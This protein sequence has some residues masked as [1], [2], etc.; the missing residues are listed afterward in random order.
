MEQHFETHLPE[1]YQAFEK[2]RSLHREINKD[3][4]LVH[5]DSAIKAVELQMKVVWSRWAGDGALHCINQLKQ[6]V[7]RAK[8]LAWDQERPTVWFQPFRSYPNYFKLDR[9]MD[10][11]QIILNGTFQEIAHT[12][13]VAD[14]NTINHDGSDIKNFLKTA[15]KSQFSVVQIS[16][17]VKDI[18]DRLSNNN[19]FF[20]ELTRRMSNLEKASNDMPRNLKDAFEAVRQQNGSPSNSFFDKDLTSGEIVKPP[21][22]KENA[23]PYKALEPGKESIDQTLEK[24]KRFEIFSDEHM[25]FIQVIIENKG[26]T[27][28]QQNQSSLLSYLLIF[29]HL[30]TMG[31]KFSDKE[32][33]KKLPLRLQLQIPKIISFDLKYYYDELAKLSTEDN[34]KFKNFAQTLSQEFK[35]GVSFPQNDS[36]S[37]T[38][39]S[40]A[41]GTAVLPAKAALGF[42]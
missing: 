19:T 37:D 15:L 35:S 2:A 8:L 20:T 38:F 18:E 7:N 32:F 3:F 39:N 5:F 4:N 16:A 6:A 1:F 11:L 29:E 9:A 13:V 31:E 24:L 42:V 23:I 34:E 41:D 22:V 30:S 28:E 40:Y 21:V 26:E 12:H 25:N 14:I 36:L 27:Q 33:K 17:Q 10:Y